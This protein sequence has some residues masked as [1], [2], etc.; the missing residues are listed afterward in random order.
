M[1]AET[2]LHRIIKSFEYIL[3]Y[4]GYSYIKNMEIFEVFKIQIIVELN[5]IW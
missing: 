4:Y 1:W 2:Y 5:K 3:I